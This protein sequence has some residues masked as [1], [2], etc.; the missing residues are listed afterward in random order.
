MLESN[1]EGMVLFARM[2]PFLAEYREA[3]GNPRNFMNAEWVATHTEAGR[4]ILEVQ[5]ARLAHMQGGK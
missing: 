4:A 2:E 3:S 1:A 5:R